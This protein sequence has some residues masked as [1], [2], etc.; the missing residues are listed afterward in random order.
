VTEALPLET[1]EELRAYVDRHVR[2]GFTPVGDIAEAACEYLGDE[3]DAAALRTYAE[4]F[5]AEALVALSDEE[6]TWPVITDCDRV[7]AAFQHLEAQGI[8]ARQ[9]FSCCQTC[10][11]GEMWDEVEASRVVGANPKGYAFYHLQDTEAAVEG[12]GLHVA[13]GAVEEGD[14]ALAAIGRDIASAL[15][16][17]GLQVNWNGE[18][19]K[20]IHVSIDWKRRR[21]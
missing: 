5:T 17:Q 10:G 6:K 14:E 11:H 19:G 4:Q 13:F 12:Q 9:D 21:E 15:R 18:T 3:A 20:R 1:A 2:G 7:D 16:A 8:V